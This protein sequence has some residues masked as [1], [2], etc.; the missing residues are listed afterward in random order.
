MEFIGTFPIDG[1]A[2]QAREA[3]AEA[4][5][6]HEFRARAEMAR[7]YAESVLADL[8]LP[9][10]PSLEQVRRLA[11]QRLARTPSLDDIARRTRQVLLEAITARLL[12]EA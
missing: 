6:W 12:R 7:G 10:M 4:R 2:A 5:V 1:I 11:E 3:L 9:H 8:H